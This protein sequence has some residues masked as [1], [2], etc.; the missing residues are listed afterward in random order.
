MRGISL[1]SG[2]SVSTARSRFRPC[3]LHV[4]LGCSVVVGTETTLGILIL[5]MM[6]FLWIL[7][8]QSKLWEHVTLPNL[9]SLTQHD[10]N[11]SLTV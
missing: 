11:L 6:F 9:I 10:L 8:K 7:L 4:V 3:S 5:M 2:E 1:R